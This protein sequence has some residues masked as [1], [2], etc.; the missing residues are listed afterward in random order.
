MFITELAKVR[1]FIATLAC[2]EGG[3][4]EKKGDPWDEEGALVSHLSRTA[5][6]RQNSTPFSAP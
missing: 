2:Q 5:L 3:E 4:R 6:P 1:T